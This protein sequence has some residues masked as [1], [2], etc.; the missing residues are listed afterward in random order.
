MNSKFYWGLGAFM[1]IFITAFVFIMQHERAE[2][3]QLKADLEAAQQKLKDSQKPKTT[4]QPVA[5]NDLGPAEPGYKWVRHGDHHHQV[6]IDAPDVWQGEPH[7]P[8]A[9]GVPVPLT[10]AK[11]ARERNQILMDHIASSPFFELRIDMY[12]FLK[13]HPD[14]DHETASPEL[15]AKWQ[16]AARAVDAKIRDAS[17]QI[18]AAIE[19]MSQDSDM[20]PIIRGP[21][22]NEGDD[23]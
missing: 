4:D 14:F 6:P 13:E 9:Q 20:S 16:D 12:N 1:V 2:I 7:L 21:V 19:T 5:E 15:D 17:A 22:H 18:S 10:A 23:K 3:R 8:V 11:T